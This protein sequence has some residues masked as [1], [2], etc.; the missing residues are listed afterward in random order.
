MSWSV[1]RCASVLQ[2]VWSCVRPCVNFFFKHLLLRKYLLDF[3][4]ISQKCCNIFGLLL[5]ISVFIADTGSFWSLR[6]DK[7]MDI[8]LFTEFLFFFFF[9]NYPSKN[10]AFME[11]SFSSYGTK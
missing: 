3:D 11:D 8:K 4:E 9:L 5:S 10:M 1:V 2:V 6:S 7:Q